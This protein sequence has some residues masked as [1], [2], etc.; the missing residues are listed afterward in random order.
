MSLRSVSVCVID[1]EGKI[2][3]E[4][5]VEFEIEAVITC[6]RE[7]G[8]IERVGLEAGV[9]SQH[10]FYALPAEGF[11]VVCMEAR[12]VAA[13]LSA[14][15]NKTDKNDARGIAQ[16]LRSGWFSPVHIKS[17]SSHYDRALPTSRKTVL[18][19]CIDLEQEIRSLF[20]AFGVRPP[21]TLGQHRF[22]EAVRPIIEADDG[23]AHA[24]LP[25]LDAWRTLYNTFI[26]LD[27]R[28]KTA[29]RKDPV[30]LLLMTAMASV[31]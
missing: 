2:V 13:A 7:L 26:E 9:I 28:V 19:K 4:R 8:T 12:Q 11:H 1:S 15:R 14:M 27:R 29:A 17:R 5:T 23:L 10:L 16:V 25:M 6:L 30:C 24:L 3:R 20:R 31:Q 22:E 18:R 21:A